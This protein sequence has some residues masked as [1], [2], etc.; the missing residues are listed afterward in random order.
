[1][2]MARRARTTSRTRRVSVPRQSLHCIALD[3]AVLRGFHEFQYEFVDR[4]LRAKHDRVAQITGIAQE[5]G[6]RYQFESRRFD[7]PAQRGLLDP[8]QRLDD[9]CA[10]S[11][12][13]GVVSHDEDT[14]RPERI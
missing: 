6:F 2:K 14:P 4:C 8:M 13:R 10:S 12:L 5:V 9:A 7:F 3:R 11:R 1:M